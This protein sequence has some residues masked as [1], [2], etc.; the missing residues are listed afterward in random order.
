M[1]QPDR[2]IP[3]RPA[4]NPKRSKRLN[5]IMGTSEKATEVLSA[6]FMTISSSMNEIRPKSGCPGQGVEL[7]SA[8]NPRNVAGYESSVTLGGNA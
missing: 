2:T 3:E 8:M 6:P 7:E 5:V 1:R 4:T